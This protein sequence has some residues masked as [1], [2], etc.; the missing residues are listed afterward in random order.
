MKL[1]KFFLCFWLLAGCS[2]NTEVG[3]IH[4]TSQEKARHLKGLQEKIT[5]VQ[6]EKQKS[7]QQLKELKIMFYMQNLNMVEKKMAEFFAFR[8]NLEKKPQLWQQFIQKELRF[9]FVQE[10]KTLVQ[11]IEECPE[12]ASKAQYMLD[13][14]LRIITELSF[15]KKQNFL[16]S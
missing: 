6:L 2:R 3:F 5:K 8:Q 14:I 12:I 1:L 15:Q 11:I 13:S 7:E 9:L 16:N 10:R 4:M